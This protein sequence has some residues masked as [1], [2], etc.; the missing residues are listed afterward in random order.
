M[1]LEYNII[2]LLVEE[3]DDLSG[4]FCNDGDRMMINPL[5]GWMDC[6][7]VTFFFIKSVN[8][9]VSPDQSQTL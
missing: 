9:V 4:K 1:V 8:S 6:N 7:V 2:S 3:E 5:G